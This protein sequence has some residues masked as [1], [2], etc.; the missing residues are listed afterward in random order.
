MV[1]SD[2]TLHNER[3]N[4]VLNWSTTPLYNKSH[5][6]F[7][8]CST[9]ILLCMLELSYCVQRTELRGDVFCTAQN[10]AVAS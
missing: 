4:L 3:T 10:E 9:Q 2:L 6:N 7:K 5:L 1:S 8:M